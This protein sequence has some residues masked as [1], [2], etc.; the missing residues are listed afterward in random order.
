MGAVRSLLKGGADP[1]QA[2]PDGS[3]AVHWAVH[4]DNL[5]MLNAL[6]DA[7]ARPD[8][9]TRYKVAPLTLAAQ[10]GNAA[11]VERLLNA[12]ANPDT[13]SEEGRSV[14]IVAAR[15]SSPAAVRALLKTRFTGRPDGILPRADRADVRRRRRRHGRRRGCYSSSA[16][17]L[18]ERSKGGYS[19]L[20]FAV[21]N[22]R[23]ETVKFLL[24]QGANI[25]DQLPDG[26][27]ALV[28]ILDADSISRRCCSFRRGSGRARPRGIRCTWSS[29][30]RQPGARAGL[31]DEQQ[32]PAS[33]SPGRLSHLDMAKKLLAKGADSNVSVTWASTASGG[34][35][36][37]KPGA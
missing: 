29:D 28:A 10:N 23:F 12:G 5:A 22:N 32:D 26:T 18:N 7:G 16:R 20:I 6:L 1:N 9:V 24:G 25:N 37:R 30:P 11:I 14:L 3:T 17:K 19:P 15:N 21:R 35:V 27:T 36:A 33:S 34:G 2:A 4:G 13:V 31:R 8:R